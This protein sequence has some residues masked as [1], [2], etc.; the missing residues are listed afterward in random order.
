M[1]LLTGSGILD[2]IPPE[3]L[4]N[5]DKGSDMWKEAVS[6]FLTQTVFMLYVILGQVLR[7]SQ[8]LLLQTASDDSLVR[9]KMTDLAHQQEK[10]MR[11][12]YS[13]QHHTSI[14]DFV[15]YHIQNNDESREGLLLQVLP[16]AQ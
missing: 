2:D 16:I 7:L 6:H 14:T 11:L 8:Y 15:Y 12:Y 5:E 13:E 9:L 4:I 10:L 3:E 1:D